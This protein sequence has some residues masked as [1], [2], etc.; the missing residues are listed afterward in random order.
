M[1]ISCRAVKDGFTDVGCEAVTNSTPIRPYK[2]GLPQWHHDKWY[3]PDHRK[4]DSLSA[5]SKHFSSVEGNNTF[6][7][8]PSELTIKQWALQTPDDYQF[9]FKFPRS[10]SHSGQLLA[11]EYLAKEFLERI[12]PLEHRIGIVWLQLSQEFSPAQLSSLSTFLARLPKHLKYGVEVRNKHF[13]NKGQDEKTLNQILIQ[14]QANR[15][16]FDT[17]CLFANYA[18]DPDTIAAFNDKPKVPTHVIATADNPLV[19]FMGPHDPALSYQALLPW[20]NKTLQWI[21]EGKTPYLF[22]HTPGNEHAPELARWFSEQIH[23]QRPEIPAITLW[24]RQPKQTEL[25]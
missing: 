24:N 2:I 20:V 6:Y 8:L 11:C 16:I 5:Y 10:I 12:A 1:A 7:G 17:R 9:C 13:F 18:D 25:W 14:H 21:D 22:F 15:V 23:Q 4:D 19:R 3:A